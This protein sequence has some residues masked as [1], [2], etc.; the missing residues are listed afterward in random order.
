MSNSI[1]YTV[2]LLKDLPDIKAGFTFPISDHLLYL[3]NCGVIGY[4]GRPKGMEEAAY[5]KMV[6]LILRY[7]DNSEWVKVE[8]DESKAYPLVCPGCGHKALFNYVDD[9]WTYQP[10]ET[11]VDEGYSYRKAGLICG[12]CGYKLHT[13]SIGK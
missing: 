9:E 1:Q 7:K 12:L 10:G 5:D 11:S 8:V 4:P 3:R 13:H 6:R 2:T